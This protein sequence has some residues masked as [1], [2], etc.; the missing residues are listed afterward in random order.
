MGTPT[1]SPE[2]TSSRLSAVAR[3]AT[4]SLRVARLRDTPESHAPVAATWIASVDAAQVAQDV[5]AAV[6]ECRQ[7]PFNGG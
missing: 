5:V 1:A 7:L 2:G 4:S 3:E 6:R